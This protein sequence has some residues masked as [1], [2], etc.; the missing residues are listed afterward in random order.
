MADNIDKR[1]G[2][3]SRY[4]DKQILTILEYQRMIS[5]HIYP[6]SNQNTECLSIKV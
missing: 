6:K 2:Q 3:Q 5:V 1:G 4:E